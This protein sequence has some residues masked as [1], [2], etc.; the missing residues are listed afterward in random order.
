MLNL[1]VGPTFKYLK[2]GVNLI[3]VRAFI[4]SGLDFQYVVP[5]MKFHSKHGK[6]LKVGHVLHVCTRAFIGCEMR[7]GVFCFS[8]A[9]VN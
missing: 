9:L 2:F 8:G 5:I 7:L 3:K 4:F 6:N 1:T